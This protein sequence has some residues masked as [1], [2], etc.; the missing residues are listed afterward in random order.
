MNLADLLHKRPRCADPI[1][2]RAE[3]GFAV[4]TMHGDG[5]VG[6]DQILGWI[7]RDVDGVPKRIPVTV[8]EDAGPSW[9]IETPDKTIDTPER[10]FADRATFVQW[11]QDEAAKVKSTP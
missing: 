6:A 4:L 3:P 11:M 10:S 5:G 7:L 1:I 2:I 9:A 8:A